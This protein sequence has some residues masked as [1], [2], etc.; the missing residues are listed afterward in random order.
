MLVYQ[1]GLRRLALLVQ[2]GFWESADELSCL[3]NMCCSKRSTLQLLND[4]VLGVF[5]HLIFERFQMTCCC[6]SRFG[7]AGGKVV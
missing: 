1:P 5:G 2:G 3:Y 6:L 7:L 4:A